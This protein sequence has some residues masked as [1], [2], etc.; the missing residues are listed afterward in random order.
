M[1]TVNYCS[2]RV[3]IFR[4]SIKERIMKLE[5]IKKYLRIE[6]EDEDSVILQTYNTAVSF[7]EEK[8]GVKYAENDSLYD[9]LICLLTAHFFDNREAVSE[10]TRSEIPYTITSL[11][12]AIEVRGD[13]ETDSEIDPEPSS[14]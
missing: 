12:K 7:A 1:Q 11:I 5:Q 9:T 10:K 8:T 3:S 2:Y 6:Y 4:H 14:G 13:I